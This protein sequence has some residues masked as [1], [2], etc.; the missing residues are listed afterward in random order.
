[1]GR[2]VPAAHVNLLPSGK[3]VRRQLQQKRFVAF[4]LP[5]EC[6]R[7]EECDRKTGEIQNEQ[8]QC[9]MTGSEQGGR[10][11][12]E[13]LQSCRTQRERYDH[14]G[15]QSQVARAHDSRPHECRDIAAEPHQQHDEAPPVQAHARHQRVHQKSSARKVAAVFHHGHDQKEQN[16]DGN[17]SGNGTNAV[18]DSVEQQAL[19]PGWCS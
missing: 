1:M 7:R 13:Y 12:Q 19:Q 14:H 2:L 10:D 15:Q 9:G 3:T 6:Y 8:H 18:I 4:Q 17:K 16:D 11:E 5:L